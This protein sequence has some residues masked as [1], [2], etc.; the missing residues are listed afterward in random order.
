MDTDTKF[1]GG[2]TP[3]GSIIPQQQ[4]QHNQPQQQMQQHNQHNPQQQHNQQQQMQQQH[5]P[6]HNQQMQQH[7]PQQHNQ[8]Q[9]NR[10]PD[11]VEKGVFEKFTDSTGVTPS[12]FVTLFVLICVIN[13]PIVID[14]E[15]KIIPL[16]L[17]LGEPPFFII[18]VN[19]L[20]IVLIY[21]GINKLRTVCA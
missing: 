15:R 3:I 21:I 9:H 19:A 10:R 6:Q 1:Q 20:I 4:P 5:N 8:Q 18:M 2:G 12:Q 7:N 11:V 16:S 13:S 14:F 17:R